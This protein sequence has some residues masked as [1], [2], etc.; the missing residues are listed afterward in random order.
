MDGE[1]LPNEEQANHH[2]SDFIGDDKHADIIYY[3]NNY[4]F[5]VI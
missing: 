5:I 3:W 1:V 2:P 4:Y